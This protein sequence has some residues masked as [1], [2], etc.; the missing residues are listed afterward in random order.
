MGY[1]VRFQRYLL[2]QLLHLLVLHDL[3][4]ELVLHLVLCGPD[5]EKANSLDYINLIIPWEWSPSGF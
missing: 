5:K 1:H 2:Q 4:V 3:A